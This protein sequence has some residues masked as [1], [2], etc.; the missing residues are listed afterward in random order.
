MMREGYQQQIREHLHMAFNLS[1]EKIDSM[2]PSFLDTIFSHLQTTEEIYA[3]GNLAG[4]SKAGHKLKG[5][6]LNLGLSD[7]AEI[8]LAVEQKAGR[9]DMTADYGAMLSRLKGEITKLR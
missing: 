3:S 5:A 6:L 9:E 8:A 2:M 7:L 4:L 1:D